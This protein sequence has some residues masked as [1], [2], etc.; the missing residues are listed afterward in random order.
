M[1]QQD[2]SFEWLRSLILIS[3]GKFHISFVKF[4]LVFGHLSRFELFYIIYILSGLNHISVSIILPLNG[5]GWQFPD[6]AF[7]KLY[8][9]NIYLINILKLK[10]YEL[11]LSVI[12][13]IST[14][15]TNGHFFLVHY[16]N[17]LIWWVYLKR[18]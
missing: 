13:K 10:T 7:W 18:L 9:V 14:K 4:L 5:L 16:I 2:W 3:I 11:L 6:I 12:H 17:L 1:H 15:F 8:S